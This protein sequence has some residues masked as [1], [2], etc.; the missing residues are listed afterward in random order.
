VTDGRVPQV[1]VEDHGV[2]IDPELAERVFERFYR[3]NDPALGYPPG[4]GLGL[5]IS[6]DLAQRSGGALVLERSVPREGS[7][8]R[9]SLH[10]PTSQ[11]DE[12]V[13]HLPAATAADR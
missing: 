1:S 6:R 12:A 5:Y 11:E 4:T 9:F 8:F 2:G 7:R 10:A 13:K 3:V